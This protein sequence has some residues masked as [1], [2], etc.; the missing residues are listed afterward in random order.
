MGKDHR[1]LVRI[2]FSTLR[3]AGWTLGLCW[4]MSTWAQSPHL[5]LDGPPTDNITR[6]T[7]AAPGASGLNLQGSP[8][9]RV[10]YHLQSAVPSG[11][12]G[13]FAHTNTEAIEA[14]YY[15]AVIGPPPT[16]V[17]PV[18]Q[19]DTNT[20]VSGLIT[21]EAGGALRWADAAGV[22][23][24]FTVGS[25]RVL[26]PQAVRMTVVT[27]FTGFPAHAGSRT[28]VQFEPDG[29]EF[30]GTGQLTI[31]YPKA[32]P[33][34]S[35]LAYSTAGD[36][37]GFH[38]VVSDS[39]ASQVMI[40]ITHFSTAG[41][42]AFGPGQIPSMDAA[43][44][45]T[46]DAAHQAQD[47]AARDIRA[48]RDAFV[49]HDLTRDQFLEAVRDAETM[50]LFSTYMR[51]IAP[52]RA[53]AQKDCGV[54]EVVVRRLD[55][56]SSR[57]DELKSKQGES[58][59]FT[60]VL[61]KVAAES[62]CNCAHQWLDICERNPAI[63]G[64]TVYKALS[65]TLI[66]AQVITGR[67]DA[68]GCDLGTDAQIMSRF[69]DSAC[70]KPWEGSIRIE[71]VETTDTLF[72][73]TG[74]STV[75]SNIEHRVVMERFEGRITAVSSQVGGTHLDGT[76]WHSWTL[77]SSGTLA[78]SLEGRRVEV[79]EDEFTRDI[80]T[81]LD[82][83]ADTRSAASE[84]L[85][86]R[87]E[88][89]QFASMSAGAPKKSYGYP[90]RHVENHLVICK[91]HDPNRKCPPETTDVTLE[92]ESP[93]QGYSADR[94]DPEMVSVEQTD[95]RLKFVWREKLEYPSI[96]PETGGTTEIS[97][98]TVDLYRGPGR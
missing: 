62:R 42:A 98:I 14:W 10:W 55:Q 4:A 49:A 24:E 45:S 68:Q 85:V 90:V 36:G 95:R 71:K 30:R 88:N 28:A 57:W 37:S 5:A 27:N 3:R 18:A 91:D 23:Y 89:N 73:T 19:I 81:W 16:F 6:L 65:E 2:P 78:A 82:N 26:R 69:A 47:Q 11:G 93:Y 22:I 52:L 31:R 7:V 33:A 51:G 58:N 34:D 38:L 43:F 74:G 66:D 46:A 21:P 72:F 59:P 44:R 13:H 9:L 48:A 17:R 1:R 96:P 25:N 53:A 87:F 40:P 76:T 12:L 70:A 54:S 75:T 79:T 20:T 64:G 35:M 63:S 83:G 41:T 86:L 60:P 77:Q 67:A 80:R 32:I 50:A 84:S 8:D 29:F 56:L 15:R 92:K 94:T 39:D 61:Q 97:T